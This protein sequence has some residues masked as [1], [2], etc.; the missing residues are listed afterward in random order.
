MNPPSSLL[1]QAYISSLMLIQRAPLSFSAQ[2]LQVSHTAPQ[3]QQTMLNTLQLILLQ[4][5]CHF[6]PNCAITQI[7]CGASACYYW[8]LKTNS[9]TILMWE[10]EVFINGKKLKCHGWL[11]CNV[12]SIKIYE[13]LFIYIYILTFDNNWA[14][15]HILK[16]FCVNTGSYSVA[17]IHVVFIWEMYMIL[18]N[19]SDC[20]L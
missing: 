20:L 18:M 2:T 3:P 4:G 19:L 11:V 1:H 12:G 16:R 17:V 9:S 6:S 15:P 5:N 14:L 10:N 7:L 13:S 8:G